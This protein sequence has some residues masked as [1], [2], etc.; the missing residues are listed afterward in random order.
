MITGSKI[1][2]FRVFTH[3]ASLS[4][5]FVRPSYADSDRHPSAPHPSGSEL[6]SK[7]EYTDGNT[8]IYTNAGTEVSIPIPSGYDVIDWNDP[9][10]RPTKAQHLPKKG[11]VRINGK[12]FHL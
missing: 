10:H 4:I 5:V 3:F 6:P 11:T 7:Y 8:N 1:G 9:I 2:V 12:F